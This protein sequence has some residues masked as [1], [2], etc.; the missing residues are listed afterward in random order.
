MIR[1][2]HLLSEEA[3]KTYTTKKSWTLKSNHYL[4]WFHTDMDVMLQ[5]PAG[6][7]WKQIANNTK[8]N[9]VIQTTTPLL[10]KTTIPKR[11]FAPEAVTYTKQPV[12]A[13]YKPHGILGTWTPQFHILIPISPELFPTE[14][15][16]ELPGT[17]ST[18]PHID[19]HAGN[20]SHAEDLFSNLQHTFIR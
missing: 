4:L 5:V 14:L 13:V 20:N 15:Q 3:A 1:L 10:I 8:G 19:I 18:W 11:E 17:W 9:E 12:K 16:N 7:V 6:T 2:K